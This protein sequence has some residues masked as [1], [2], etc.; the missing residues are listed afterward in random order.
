M[1][2]SKVTVLMSTFNGDKYLRDQIESILGQEGVNVNLIVRDDG[3]TDNTIAVLN[4]YSNK[5]L[6]KW[7]SGENLGAAKSFF[8]LLDVSPESDY[9][10]FSDQD[11]VWIKEKLRIAISKIKKINDKLP[12]LYT[13]N[14][15]LVDQNLK[16]IDVDIRH[17]TTTT[18]AN[19]I[20]CSCCTGCTMVFNKYLRNL[21]RDNKKPDRFYMH[22]DWIHKVCLAVDGKV[23]YDSKP[24]LLYRQH[25]NNIDGG[26]HSF[27]SKIVKLKSDKYLMSCQLEEL[28]EIYSKNIPLKNKRLIKKALKLGKGNMIGRMKLAFNN[29]YKIRSNKRLNNEFRTQLFLNQW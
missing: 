26:I 23:I 15:T 24:V 20:V 21:I 28:Y 29:Q 7:Y 13:A 14:Y 2:K 8:D 10:A 12:I 5:G 9:Y 16:T 11:D 18:F 4:D 22:D 1:A 19:S 3:S 6:L 27:R 17:V 25:G